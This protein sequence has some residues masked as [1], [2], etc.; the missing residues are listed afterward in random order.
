MRKL[1]SVVVVLCAA[2][3]AHAQEPGGSA[4]WVR[5]LDEAAFSARDTAEN[6]VFAGKMWLSNGWAPPQELVRDLWCSSDGRDWK[7]VLEETPYDPYSEMVA[8]KDRMWAI[9]GSVWSTTDGIKWERVAEK[10]PY[11]ALGYGEAVVHHD[12]IWQ[13]G[14]GEQVW[15]TDDG[16]NWTCATQNA[17]YGKRSAAAVTSFAG[18]LWLM[19]GSTEKANTPPEKHYKQFTTFNDV[20]CSEDGATWT[21]VLE[22][23]PWAPRMWTVAAV[24]AGRIWLIGGFDNANSRNLGDVWTTMDGKHW[25]QFISPQQFGPRHEVTPYVFDGSLWVVAGNTW[26]VVN[27]VWRL[28]LRNG[29]PKPGSRPIASQPAMTWRNARELTVEGRAWDDTEAFYD[30]LPARAK[31]RVTD[32]VWTLSRQSA[33]MAVRF[34]T[35]A[36]NIAAR[37]TLTSAGLAMEHM[38]ATGM[39]GLD[40]YVK[41]AGTWRWI[42]AGRPRKQE[43]EAVLASGIP[44]GT[45]EYILYLPLYNGVKSVEIGVPQDATLSPA[46]ARPM[47]DAI[48]LYGTSIMQGGCASRPGMAHAAII[49]RMLDRPTVNLGFSGS[50]KMEPAMADLLAELDPAIYVL[51]C[52]PNMTTDM[53][54]ERVEPFVRT[55]RAKHPRTPIVL[56]ENIVPQAAYVLPGPRTLRTE[57]NAA[58]R[59]AYEH[60]VAEGVTGLTY[61]PGDRLLG[62]DG[63]GTVDGVHPTDLGFQ[64]FAE[65]MTPGLRKILRDNEQVRTP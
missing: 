19:G 59:A 54:R 23:A 57:K 64:R 53:V 48:V 11:G 27:D 62:T 12:R 4:G 22:H 65:A 46:P 9:K 1:L 16:V 5:V 38:P 25:E 7:R 50:G 20:W 24:Y 8:Y 21:R 29:M 28:T 55:L 26:P 37:W 15:S 45:R 61:A 44:A 10:T 51:D 52:L 40:L 30:R 63:E 41:D 39:S 32:S 42:G 6:C 34:T 33:G 35:D 14:S 2:A 17:P 31:G 36:P 60:L 18:K 13:L 3:A 43:N 47:S 49:G 56:V 58:L